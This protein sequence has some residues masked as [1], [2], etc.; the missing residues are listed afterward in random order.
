MSFED[1]TRTGT[2]WVIGYGK[3]QELPGEFFCVG[4]PAADDADSFTP[5]A[6]ISPA[7]SVNPDDRHRASVMCAAPAMLIAL[8]E[9][10]KLLSSA[11]IAIPESMRRAIDAATS[12]LRAAPQDGTAA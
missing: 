9:T 12:T 7:S 2:G 1:L 3:V 10:E 4:L 11:R 8:L 5:I 6:L